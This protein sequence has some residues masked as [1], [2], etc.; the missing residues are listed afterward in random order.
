VPT[1]STSQASEPALVFERLY[2]ESRDDV[3]AYAA[4]LLRDRGAAEEVTA[5]ERREAAALQS[6]LD[7]VRRRAGFA[8]VSLRIESGTERG[9]S[10]RWD[11]G[12]A[13][14]D[15]ARILTVATAVALIGL[16]VTG[17]LALIAVAIWLAQRLW[18]RRRRLSALA[19]AA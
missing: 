17:P 12:D 18:V 10:G 5:G 16:A 19:Q 7:Q 4:G 13:L 6:R 1:A 2:R 3:Y 11:I 9:S 15:A 8:H 14:D